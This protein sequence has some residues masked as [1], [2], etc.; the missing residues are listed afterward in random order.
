MATKY[1]ARNQQKQLDPAVSA[2]RT[3]CET[4]ENKVTQELWLCSQESWIIHDHA[5]GMTWDDH[6]VLNHRSTQ[7]SGSGSKET[8]VPDPKDQAQAQGLSSVSASGD[9]GFAEAQ[10]EGFS[11]AQIEIIWRRGYFCGNL[12]EFII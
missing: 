2:F 5:R 12:M 3:L 10:I 8:T 4:L 11:E 6:S 7:H 1:I 9:E